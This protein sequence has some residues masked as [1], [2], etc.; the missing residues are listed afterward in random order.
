M[1]GIAFF[2]REAAISAYYSVLLLFFISCLYTIFHG[3][4]STGFVARHDV[5]LFGAIDMTVMVNHHCA[6]FCL[7]WTHSINNITLLYKPFQPQ[8]PKNYFLII[9]LFICLSFVFFNATVCNFCAYRW[10]RGC[11]RHVISIIEYMQNLQRMYSAVDI[12]HIARVCNHSIRFPRSA[13][14][15]SSIS[16]GS[17]CGICVTSYCGA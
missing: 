13:L 5:S 16:Q 15:L 7:L 11:H 17:T 2:C 1:Q 14:L 4:L 9:G 10:R 12:R 6:A 3:K 8:I